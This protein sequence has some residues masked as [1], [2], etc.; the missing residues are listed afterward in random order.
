MRGAGPSQRHMRL[1]KLKE[2]ARRF[3]EERGS[4]L[5]LV[6]FIVL[7]LTILGLSVL[8]AAVGGAQRTE[9]RKNDVQSLHLA[10]KTLDEAVAYITARLNQT[11]QASIVV[12]Q[13]DLDNAIDLFLRNLNDDQN[14]LL[15]STD[16]LQAD[17]KKASGKITSID[18]ETKKDP[19]SGMP[20]SYRLTLNSQA[21][22]NG[23]VRNLSQVVVI[24]TFPDFLN[25]TLGSEHNLTINGSPYIKGNIY[26]GDTLTISDTANYR[27]KG[28]DHTF[29]SKLFQLEGEAH[30]QSLQKLIYQDQIL[31]NLTADKITSTTDMTGKIKSDNVKIK[32][33]RSFVEVNV[34]SSFTDKVA[35]AMGGLAIRSEILNNVEKGTL[36]EYLIGTYDTIF[37]HPEVLPPKPDPA[38]TTEIGL[39]AQK[40]YD[41]I[42]K[43]LTKPSKSLV[44]EGDLTLDGIELAGIQYANKDKN[45]YIIDGNLK[46]DNSGRSTPVQVQANILVTGKVEI[47]GK[48]EFDSTIF[49]L[50]QSPLTGSDKEYTT[51]VEDASIQGMN[52]K[53]LVLISQG[54][55]LINRLAAFTNAAS[56]KPLEAFFYTDSDALLYGVGSVFSLSGGFFAK[57]DL[58]INA[59]RG[60]ATDEDGNFLVIQNDSQIR[61]N[62][63]YNNKV[64]A[65]QKAGLPRV[66][67]INISV[68]ELKLK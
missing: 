55:I 9:T 37:D 58:T 47:R 24:D 52:D 10:E 54:P 6:M 35:E 8:T 51:I 25:Y 41:E 32:N 20:V 44:Y 63:S 56:A 17:G 40:S 45:W 14:I 49:A 19:T 31:G 38:D 28:V 27:Y 48:V 11:I 50:Q 61:F 53:E 16:L 7:L 29:Y 36:A 4:A 13:S 57:G 12:S 21:E 64:F 42:V 26:A 59:V 22:I 15:A 60:S 30:V 5:V 18:Y 62:A 68:E 1:K 43:Q 3:R 46:I 67:S 33:H 66:Q 34:I 39:K 65:D 2:F 23:V